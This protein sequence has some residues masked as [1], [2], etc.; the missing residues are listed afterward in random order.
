MFTEGVRERV[1]VCVWYPP[2]QEQVSELGVLFQCKGCTARGCI[3]LVIPMCPWC[4]YVGV[5]QSVC[6]S[7]GAEQTAL[8]VPQD[9]Q[10]VPR[11]W[12]R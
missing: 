2:T 12:P 4:G 11:P 10:R 3:M 5:W 9:G 7:M 1:C 8:C 6:H